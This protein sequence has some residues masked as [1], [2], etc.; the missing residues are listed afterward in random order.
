MTKYVAFFDLDHTILNVS[1]GRI[2]FKGSRMHKLIGRKEICKAIIMTMLNRMGILSAGI[3][4][5]A[6][7]EVV[8]GNEC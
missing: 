7:F 1:S 5:R 3:G 8:P 4:N 2:M 6:L